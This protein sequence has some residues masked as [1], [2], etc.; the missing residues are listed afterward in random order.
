MPT[1]A[2]LFPVVNPVNVGSY[3]IKGTVQGVQ[4]NLVWAGVL[5]QTYMPDTYP[6]V[7]SLH[8]GLTINLGQPS[9]T[10][11]SAVTTGLG[12][13]LRALNIPPLTG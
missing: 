10:A 5:P 4:A 9:V 3:L 8:P 7:A 11:V 12:S 1:P 6:Y 13:L 2:S